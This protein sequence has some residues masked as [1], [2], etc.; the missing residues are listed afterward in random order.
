MLV[1]IPHKIICNYALS[2]AYIKILLMKA[3]FAFCVCIVTTQFALAQSTTKK[4]KLVWS[5]EFNYTGLPDKTK[6]GYEE[7][8]IRNN[9]SQ[10]Y[11]VARAENASVA[12]GMLTIT[13]RKEQYANRAYKPG[14]NDW[15]IKDSLAGYT[16][17]ALITLN[18]KHFTYGRI[19]VRAKIP[20]GLGV[21]PAIWM[22][23]VDRGLVRWPYCGE[24]DIMEFVGHDS[25]HIYGTVHFADTT[26]K[27]QHAS[28]GGKIETLQ[29]YND[30]HVYA[31]EW[32][33]QEINFFFDDSMYHHFD[34]NKATYKDEN[35][36]RKPFYVL[37]N[38]ALGGEWGKHIDD[39]NLPQQFLIDYVRVY[40]PVR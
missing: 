28:S 14:G 8:F 23:G 38:L 20:R 32:N 2:S 17:A 16:S 35:P 27:R 33:P 1:T 9:E 30:F 21:W 10:Y 19:E 6:W 34:I 15:K 29:P 31:V 18:K 11:T 13:G 37:I 7:G 24:V 4:W 26:D 40:A 25:M 12:N 5:D 3:L 36:F 22:L 39:A